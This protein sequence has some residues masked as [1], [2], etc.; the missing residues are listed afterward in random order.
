MSTR[1]SA[2]WIAAARAG[3]VAVAITLCLPAL[4]ALADWREY[5]GKTLLVEVKTSGRTID[6]VITA[7]GGASGTDEVSTTDCDMSYRLYL[8]GKGRLFMYSTRIHCAGSS[9]HDSD[10][11]TGAIID[12]TVPEGQI[13]TGP[14]G[15][16][17][18]Y[19]LRVEGEEVV[20]HQPQTDYVS[21]GDG[22]VITRS[23]SSGAYAWRIRFADDCAL[24]VAGAA[25]YRMEYRST[26]SDYYQLK[27][28]DWIYE[29]KT[30]SCQVVDGFQ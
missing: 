16:A 1:G 21:S 29:V 11:I 12:L 6:D 25:S 7:R 9:P 4:P 10:D 28:S 5:M 8:S 15:P 19:S 26:D 2:G 3:V 20:L 30:V 14:T 13:D 17:T 23:N 22:Y 18:P 27:D 24:N